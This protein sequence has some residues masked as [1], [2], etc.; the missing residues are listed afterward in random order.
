MKKLIAFA[1]LLAAASLMAQSK[2][3]QKQDT[4]P[5]PIVGKWAM[6]LEMSMGTATPT[7]EITKQDGEKIVGS[8]TGRYGTSALAGTVK[9]RIIEFV[10]SMVAEGDTIPMNFSGEISADGK[11]ITKGKAILGELGD[12]TWSAK[13]VAANGE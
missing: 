8:Y 6:T 7:L 5:A 11:E 2:P 4:K 1:M 10:V 13:R 12:A 3:E 9:N